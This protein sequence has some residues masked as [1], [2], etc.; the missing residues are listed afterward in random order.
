MNWSEVLAVS[1]SYDDY[2]QQ[3]GSEIDR[4]KW[5]RSLDATPLADD[6]IALLGSFRR[7]MTL[8]CMAGAWCGDC[9]EHVPILQRF[10]NHCPLITLRLI[11]RDAHEALKSAL[12]I[13][14]SAR[15]PQTVVL[16]ED[17]LWV[18]RWG[19]RPLSKYRDLAARLEGAACSSGLILPGDPLRVAIIQDWLDELH[20]CQLILR[21]SPSLR[22]RYND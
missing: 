17:D 15:V 19:D 22:K 2:L 20:R 7:R 12:T 18:D 6:Q 1:L 9:V 14:G 4:D 21:T 8:L 11:D 13:C 10:T 3:Y 5:Q 16:S